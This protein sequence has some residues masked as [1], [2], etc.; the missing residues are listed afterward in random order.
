M[1]LDARALCKSVVSLAPHRRSAI[2]TTVPGERTARASSSAERSA[3][4]LARG[5]GEA[6]Y[7]FLIR[8]DYEVAVT[9]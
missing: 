9:A 3:A 8:G 1:A 2:G 4:G 5:Q 7:E 6:E